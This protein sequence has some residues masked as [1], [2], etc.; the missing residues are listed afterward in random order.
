MQYNP[1][2][3]NVRPIFTPQEHAHLAVL[4]QKLPLTILLASPRNMEEI[5]I[6]FVHIFARQLQS[7]F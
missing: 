7:L 1:D 3:L 4:S 2:F 6:D 5:G